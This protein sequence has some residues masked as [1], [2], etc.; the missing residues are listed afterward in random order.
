MDEYCGIVW[1]MKRGLLAT[2]VKIKDC[3]QSQFYMDNHCFLLV[4]IS[5]EDEIKY[6]EHKFHGS[7]EKSSNL[8]R[9]T[10]S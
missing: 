4:S 9:Y 7:I 5:N 6:I 1:H 10:D 8:P 3:R 2:I